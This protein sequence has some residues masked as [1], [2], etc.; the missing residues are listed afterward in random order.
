MSGGNLRRDV[1][2]E[3][4]V[5]IYINNQSFTRGQGRAFHLGLTLERA[6][7]DLVSHNKAGAGF[8]SPL[9]LRSSLRLPIDQC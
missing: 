7:R 5:A 2:Q 6:P 9:Q 4:A 1:L 3:E 8:S